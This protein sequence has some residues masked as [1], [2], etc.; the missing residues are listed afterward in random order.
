MYVLA[1]CAC[2]VQLLLCASGADQDHVSISD[3]VTFPGLSAESE[4]HALN[5]PSFLMVGEAERSELVPVSLERAASEPCESDCRLWLSS[6]SLPSYSSQL[7]YSLASLADEAGLSQNRSCKS[8]GDIAA[9][10]VA[11]AVAAIVFQASQTARGTTGSRSSAMESA[12]I[13]PKLEPNSP[14]LP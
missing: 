5:W 13:P 10:S 7:S 6:T 14:S 2:S 9:R 4:S 8:S 3:K 12:G 11:V 1:T